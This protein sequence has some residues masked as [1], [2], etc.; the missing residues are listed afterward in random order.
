[1]NTSRATVAV[2]AIIL[3][4]LISLTAGHAPLETHAIDPS[5]PPA[6]VAFSHGDTRTAPPQEGNVQ[7]LTY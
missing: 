1:M 7:D 5:V 2:S 4:A 3:A 6:T